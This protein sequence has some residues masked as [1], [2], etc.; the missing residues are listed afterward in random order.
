MGPQDEKDEF[1]PADSQHA[2]YLYAQGST[3]PVIDPPDEGATY[4]YTPSS[5]TSS[6]GMA[7]GPGIVSA[8]PADYYQS[9]DGMPLHGV[10]PEGQYYQDPSPQGPFPPQGPPHALDEAYSYYQA[11]QPAPPPPPPTQ[12]PHQLDPQS[13]QRDVEEDGAFVDSSVPIDEA[14]AHH[15]MNRYP[16]SPPGYRPAESASKMDPPDD[17]PPSLSRD[18]IPDDEKFQHSPVYYPGMHE[19]SVDPRSI[20]PEGAGYYDRDGEYYDSP[21][22]NYLSQQD[23]YYPREGEYYESPDPHYRNESHNGEYYHQ[24]EEKN[25]FSP[26]AVSSDQD[27]EYFRS[28]DENDPP[29]NPGS[30]ESFVDR[31]GALSPKSDGSRATEVSHS[32]AALRTAHDYLKKTR[33]KRMES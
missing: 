33:Q 1:I 3:S 20:D 2:E 18:D 15:Q 23:D 11:H 27:A 5:V 9:E 25:A 28:P 13:F 19:E 7:P 22:K 14:I 26:G 12:H 29:E 32:S 17:E 24:H 4:G 30:P 16:I 21:D 10:P 31:D 8:S 6:M